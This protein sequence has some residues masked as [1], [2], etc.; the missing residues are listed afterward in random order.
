VIHARRTA[1]FAENGTGR[2]TRVEHAAAEPAAIVVDAKVAWVKA[3]H[4]A[5]ARLLSVSEAAGIPVRDAWFDRHTTLLLS[6]TSVPDFSEAARLLAEAGASEIRC[7]IAAVSAVAVGV[8]RNAADLA[9]GLACVPA[10]ALTTCLSPLR[11]CAV[12]PSADAPGLERAWHAL[13]S[14]AA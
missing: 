8:G 13:F 1:D 11:L 12:V 6:L 2:E 5:R 4:S 10:S 9:R 7:D 3:E 14:R